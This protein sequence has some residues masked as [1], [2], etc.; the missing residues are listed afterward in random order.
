MLAV[1]SCGNDD[2]PTASSSDV[3]SSTAASGP[4]A[5]PASSTAA[6][7]SGTLVLSWAGDNIL[8]TDE[9]FG[10]LTLPAAWAQSGKDP[11]YFF[12]NV[13]KY[14]AADDLT[15]ANFEVALTSSRKKRDKGG[16]EVYHFYGE[17]AVAKTLTAGGIEVV[18]I[19][20][21]HTWD[22]GRKGFTDTVEALDEAGVQYVGAGNPGY[23]GSD[24]DHPLIRDV[25]GVGIGLLSYQTWEDTPAIRKQVRGDIK[26]LR[27]QGADVVIPYFHWGIEAVH[28]PYEVQRA[29]ARVA[30]DAGADAVIGTH[31]HVLQSMDVYK[32]R[33]IAYS[34]GNFSFGGNTNPSD[35][36]TMILQTRLTVK[37]GKV[38]GVDYRIIPT[39]LSRTE[40]YNDYVPT[41]YGRAEARQVV[42][43]MNQISP[44]LDGTVSQRFTPVPQR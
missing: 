12:Q 10:G 35:K 41:P 13:K 3:S 38:D 5:S 39:R 15:I 14:F 7:A 24:F 26:K 32:G 37:D 34:L 4:S 20:N 22:Y 9:K 8:G 27:A 33:L 42:A 2:A 29:L 16:G 23:D 11:D 44:S 19:A 40:A 31:P 18:T 36:R 25:K 28:E 30:I 43:F 21:N 6:K 17:P 1:T